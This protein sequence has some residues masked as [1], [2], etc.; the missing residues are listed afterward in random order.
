M[1]LRTCVDVSFRC[2]VPAI[3]YVYA[4]IAKHLTGCAVEIGLLDNSINKYYTLF[5]FVIYS[6]IQL[7]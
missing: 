6:F 5:Y 4:L 1:R 3:V 2:F 7:P